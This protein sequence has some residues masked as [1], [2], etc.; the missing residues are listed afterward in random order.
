MV[1]YLI[2]ISLI[3]ILVFGGGGI[4]IPV[5]ESFYVDIFH[6]LTT[7]E[8]YNLV[9]LANVFPGALGGKLAAYALSIDYGVSGALIATIVFI[10]IPV[11]VIIV[12][13]KYIDKIKKHPLYIMLN[14]GLKPIIIGTF[15]AISIN[16]IKI[17]S[18]YLPLWV[19]IIYLIGSCWLIARYKVNIA[20]LIVGAMIIN[21]LIYFF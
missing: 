10:I 14:Q 18:G 20:L 16:F 8:Y 17:G 21:S 1:P 12:L 15:I 2:V 13:F 4:F 11:I 3:N 9:A 19:N 6:L 7:Q 5:Y